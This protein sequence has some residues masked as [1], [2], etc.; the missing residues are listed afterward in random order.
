MDR[1]SV[2][3]STYNEAEATLRCAIESILSQTHRDIEFIIV[4]DNPENEAVHHIVSSYAKTDSRITVVDN[5]KNLGLVGALNLA[6]K[7]VTGTYVARMDADDISLPERLEAQLEYLK[8][9]DLDLVGALVER[10][11]ESGERLPGLE[12]RHYSSAVIMK[13]LRISNCVPHPTWLLKREVYTAL[14]GYRDMP[15]CEDYDFLLRALK[16]GFRIG[17]CDKCLLQYRIS[18]QG[19]SQ[20]GLFRQQLSARYLSKQF[21]RL[22]QVTAEELSRFLDQKQAD[23]VA[24]RYQ[25]ANNLFMEALG[26]R[27]K[28]PL[29][30]GVL[31]LRSLCVSKQYRQKFYDMFKLKLIRKMY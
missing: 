20:S 18:T 1:I 28:N 19:I 4:P 8:Q 17:L 31:L 12:S 23:R 27:R 16:A 30:M 22:E 15:R 14:G 3:M 29:K 7:H 24:E 11:D 5:N 13:S 21:N 6:L 2:I 10:I 25:R 9:N 26:Y